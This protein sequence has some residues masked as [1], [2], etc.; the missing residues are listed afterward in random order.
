MFNNNQDLANQI[1]H[2]I[3]ELRHTGNGHGQMDIIG[4]LD[5]HKAH[6]ENLVR[7]NAGDHLASLVGHGALGV[8]ESLLKPSKAMQNG[9]Y[10]PPP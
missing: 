8:E 4:A 2:K 5:N 10:F 9:K 6:M 3:D 1:S 7:N